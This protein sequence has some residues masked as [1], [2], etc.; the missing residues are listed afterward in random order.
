[1]KQVR[2]RRGL[3]HQY[4]HNMSLFTLAIITSL[5]WSKVPAS[6]MWD[7]RIKFQQGNATK[8]SVSWSLINNGK[9]VLGYSDCL[10]YTL[11]LHS[12]SYQ[13][14]WSPNQMVTVYVGWLRLQKIDEIPVSIGPRHF[15]ISQ[16]ETS[17]SEIFKNVQEGDRVRW[18]FPSSTLEDS[19]KLELV[20][21]N[22]SV[23]KLADPI[24]GTSVW[25]Q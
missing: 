7:P 16:D 23:Y 18:H 12:F 20:S 21:S 15:S 10:V 2:Q 5:I 8:Q 22:F 24:Q 6:S 14:G 4:S 17:P 3:S 1:M 11:N 9:W 13:L 19:V 25:V